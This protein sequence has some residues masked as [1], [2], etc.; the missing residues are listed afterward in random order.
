[1]RKTAK[2]PLPSCQFL[3]LLRH[4]ATSPTNVRARLAKNHGT[5]HSLKLDSGKFTRIAAP[6]FP[7]PQLRRLDSSPYSHSR[8]TV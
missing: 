5:C 2:T 3:D 4:R 8:I 6:R 7:R 1:M